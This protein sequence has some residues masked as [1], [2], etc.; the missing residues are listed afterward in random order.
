MAAAQEKKVR[1]QCL[2]NFTRSVNVFNSLHAT[3]PLIDQLTQVFNKVMSRWD[4][5]EAA[6]DAFIEVVNDA[7]T[8]MQYLDEPESRYQKVLIAYDSYKKKSIE[9]EYK[10]KE[11]LTADAK[12][13]DDERRIKEVENAAN[14]E[15]A[16][17]QAEKK[18]HFESTEEELKLEVDSF[19]ACNN[20]IQEVMKDAAVGD[21]RRAFEKLEDQFHA[22]QK[23]LVTLGS[24]DPMKD[25]QQYKT[26]FADKVEK[27]FGV[28]Q[29]WFLLQLKD[30]E[31]QSP[32]DTSSTTELS[33]S[34]SLSSSSV[35]KKEPVSLP[36]FS[37]D[38]SST[39]SPFLMYPIWR[40]KWDTLISEYKDVYRPNVLWE[41]LDEHARSV[42]TGHE[43]D[44]DECMK[45]LASFYGNP[46]KVVNCIMAEVD[47][48][49]EISEGDYE[50]LISFCTILEK[51][52][53]RLQSMTPPLGHQMS[54]LSTMSMILCKFPVSIAVKWAEYIETIED[55]DN[56]IK[57]MPFPTFI[58]WLISQKSVWER[59]AAV[60]RRRGGAAAL[61]NY[62]GGQDKPPPP[63]GLK[64]FLC[65]KEGH[66]QRS[67]P[68]KKEKEKK[69]SSKRPKVKKHW[70]AFHKD[71]PTKRCSSFNCQDLRKADATL[72]IKL[73]KEN[74]DCLYCCG[75]HLPANCTMQ[76]RVCGGGKQ[77][78][79]C[80]QSHNLHE[81]YCPAARVFSIQQV[82]VQQDD[83]PNSVLLLIMNVQS[84]RRGENCTV[85]WDLGS[86]SNFV[87]EAFARLM[88]FKGVQ[89]RLCVTTL[90]GAVTEYTVTRY[91]CCIRDINNELF[92]FEAYGL[93]CVTGAL[94]A[95]DS[96]SIKK[97]FPM[98][99][100]QEVES[101]KRCSNVDYLIGAQH[102]SCHPERAERTNLGGDLWLYEG[103][104][105]RCIGGSHPDIKEDTEKRSVHYF[106]VNYE[107]N[108]AIEA[109]ENVN[110]HSLEYCPERV[111]SY[112]HK[113]GYCEGATLG[114][115]VCNPSA[116]YHQV[117]KEKPMLIPSSPIASS[118]PCENVQESAVEAVHCHATKTSL[119]QSEELFFRSEALGTTVEPQCGSCKC[120]NCPI[121]GS[122]YSFHEQKQY[123]LIQ[124]NLTY[125]E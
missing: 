30:S 20:D 38:E 87:R 32:S 59:V 75:D 81:L 11:Q 39:P 49:P 111:M 14:I 23:I 3:D 42:F 22:I 114:K 94:G 107:V 91:Q 125:N 69:K 117:V 34:S 44:Y 123:D 102:P 24:I 120:T 78:R 55:P 46:Y 115:P 65:K 26:L 2:M 79:G 9:D 37:G 25:T 99:T 108:E 98:L 116:V 63:S 31:Q 62:A 122:F 6:Q 47:A 7:D 43:S 82:H 16:R 74:G 113:S 40:K 104:F 4:A 93:E 68:N 89:K 86:T 109:H 64:C 88:N 50:G 72:R 90:A 35:T 66:K 57:S 83:Q 45:R 80:T 106:T 73:L 18:I 71:D 19:A 21:K 101:L 29:K 56:S 27:P 52:Y 48:P 110:P 97:L 10:L 67:C 17:I 103:R 112:V 121:P 96:T 124:K 100:N 77:D 118:V 105:G 36:S 15:A 41:K 12:K 54:N 119:I 33:S 61:C 95:I 51:N 85:F 92:Y 8:E 28:T 58:E 70:C 13:A 60:E 84:P 5:L 76:N 1:T 53:N